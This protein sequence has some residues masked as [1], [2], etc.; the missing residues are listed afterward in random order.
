MQLYKLEGTIKYSHGSCYDDGCYI[1]NAVIPA[2]DADDATAFARL[3][4]ER[5]H[6][7]HSW[8][9]H[10]EL[11]ATLV[12][13]RDTPRKEPKKVTEW[14]FSE[15]TGKKEICWRQSPAS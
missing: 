7:Y 11:S 13:A 6:E 3:L 14:C 5:H 10:Y 1:I 12:E 8:R 9:I 4:L 15:E 2:E